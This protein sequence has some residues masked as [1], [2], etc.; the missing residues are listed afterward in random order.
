MKNIKTITTML[1]FILLASA[2]PQ[3]Q[4]TVNKG[5]LPVYYDVVSDISLEY[6]NALLAGRIELASGAILHIV[7]YKT[8]DDNAINKW[9]PGD[10]VVFSSYAHKGKLILTIDRIVKGMIEKKVEPYAIFDTINSSKT[11]LSIVE[12]RENGKFVKLSDNTVWE[13]GFYNQF[14][15]EDWKVGER[16]MVKGPNSSGYFDFINVD[17]SLKHNSYSATGYFVVN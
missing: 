13:F 3:A 11:M 15:T 10:I 14:F 1:L 2:F 7:D 6:Q 17:V 16:V 4:A 8:R 9:R 5:N 12:I